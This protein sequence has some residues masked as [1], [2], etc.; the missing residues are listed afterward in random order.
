MA[1]LK[2]AVKC[3]IYFILSWELRL[4]LFCFFLLPSLSCL[5]SAIHSVVQQILSQYLP[6]PATVLGVGNTVRKRYNTCGP[7]SHGA[8][9]QMKF[10]SPLGKMG[11]NCP[12]LL[13]II[14]DQPSQSPDHTNREAMNPSRCSLVSQHWTSK[15]CI[16]SISL[17]W[18]PNKN[19]KGIQFRNAG[20]LHRNNLRR[21]LRASQQQ[22]RVLP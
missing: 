21:D 22:K 3:F 17:H 19:H 6:T 1:F 8:H 5:L 18:R 16:C 12:L 4:E 14:K 9:R 10:S 11:N 7:F 20:E 2:K 13:A 15:F